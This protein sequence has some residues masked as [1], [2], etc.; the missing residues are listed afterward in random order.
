[1]RNSTVRCSL[2]MKNTAVHIEANALQYVTRA[3][4]RSVCSIAPSKFSERTEREHHAKA[5]LECNIVL[6][7]TAQVNAFHISLHAFVRHKMNSVALCR[8]Y[9]CYEQSYKQYQRLAEDR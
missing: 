7:C 2:P 1:M 3:I 9:T 5:N 8:L 4:V 6:Y